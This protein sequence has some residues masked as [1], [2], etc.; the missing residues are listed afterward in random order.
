MLSGDF[1]RLFGDCQSPPETLIETARHSG[2]GQILSED[3]HI[4]SGDY[5]GLC[6]D[7]QPPDRYCLESGRDL[8]E[9]ARDSG[10]CQRLSGD[11]IEW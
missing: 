5:K 4:L 6:R 2:E 10:D 8:V 9:T 1:R 11:I 7:G 3:C